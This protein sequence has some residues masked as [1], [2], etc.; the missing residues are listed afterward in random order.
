[1]TI[2]IKTN[3]AE[4]TEIS[5]EIDGWFYRFWYVGYGE[6]PGTIVY[7]S[8]N[9]SFQSL[10]QEVLGTDGQFHS[11]L[12]YDDDQVFADNYTAKKNVQVKVN[13]ND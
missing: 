11:F 4:L 2:Q 5:E 1:M 6:K 8:H 9:P 7:R 13:K 10:D 3:I 12:D